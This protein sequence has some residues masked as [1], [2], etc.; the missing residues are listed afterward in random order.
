M[1]SR[2]GRLMWLRHLGGMQ[3]QDPCR[4]LTFHKPEGTECIGRPVRWLEA[5]EDLKILG[6]S[7]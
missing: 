4:I 3:E 6:T 1:L 2:A 5:A 7:F